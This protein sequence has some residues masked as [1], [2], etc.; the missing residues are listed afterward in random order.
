MA[1]KTLGGKLARPIGKSN[2][3]TLLAQK[4]SIIEV[5]TAT[6]TSKTPGTH[7]ESNL[8]TGSTRPTGDDTRPAQQD[9]GQEQKRKKEC[10]AGQSLGSPVVL[11]RKVAGKSQ[12]KSLSSVQGS[13]QGN[14]TKL[15]RKRLAEAVPEKKKKTLTRDTKLLAK[16]DSECKDARV[17]AQSLQST[18][19]ITE[20]GSFHKVGSKLKVNH[21]TETQKSGKSALV[22]AGTK[23]DVKDTLV[24]CDRVAPVP[25]VMKRASQERTTMVLEKSWSQSE[26]TLVFYGANTAHQERRERDQQPNPASRPIEQRGQL[27]AKAQGDPP[28]P[29]PLRD[30][31]RDISEVRNRLGD[32][33][34]IHSGIRV[35][36]PARIE[37][38][39]EVAHKSFL[40]SHT[41]P[42]LSVGG[43]GPRSSEWE[44]DSVSTRTSS[45][46]L[47]QEAT[48]QP[49]NGEPISF[50]AITQTY[51]S[52]LSSVDAS[53]ERKRNLLKRC[54]P[55]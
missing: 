12:D 43:D 53:L 1:T 54:K 48:L 40:Q 17:T 26:T 21:K 4:P 6:S 25:V 27:S 18:P 14:E 11:P 13:R 52:S 44:Q 39:P 23:A 10:R 35:G 34:R 5:A 46:L 28:V 38:L 2:S 32:S 24:R 41:K 3:E 51:K 16:D 30:L 19:L 55:K 36:I 8:L 31:T 15:K 20:A 42:D 45:P 47:S 9:D 33:N 22:P 29:L 50:K 37:R 49:V 7:I